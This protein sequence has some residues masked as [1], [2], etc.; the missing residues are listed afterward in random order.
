[1]P[2][3]PHRQTHFLLSSSSSPPPPPL[4]IFT[5]PVEVFDQSP[6]RRESLNLR[7]GLPAGLEGVGALQVAALFLNKRCYFGWPF[8]KE[9]LVSAVADP[10]GVVEATDPGVLRAYGDDRQREAFRRAAGSSCAELRRKRGMLLD[11]VQCSVLLH[12]RPLQGLV[13]H[14]DGALERLYDKAAVP[15]PLQ[16]TLQRH[17]N[18]D[19]R[20][21]GLGLGGAGDA[22]SNLIEWA[23]SFR[24]GT[25]CLFLGRTYYG[26]V[27]TVLGPDPAHAGFLRVAV[28]PQDGAQQ[29]AQTARRVLTNPAPPLSPAHVVARKCGVSARVLGMVTAAVWVRVGEDDRGRPEKRDLGLNVKQSELG[30]GRGGDA[31]GLDRARL[32]QIEKTSLPFSFLSPYSP[33]APRACTCPT[34]RSPCPRGSPGGS[35]RSPC[36]RRWRPTS[37]AAPGS[38][39]RSRRG[40][41]AATCSRCGT[42]SGRTRRGRRR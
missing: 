1:M 13:R 23:A 35:T 10:R 27:A 31:T 18:P 20:T 16:V 21:L 24:E 22:Q 11:E 12:L 39:R 29:A 7:M 32:L 17:P 37:C 41:T 6:A 25:P 4:Q 2:P 30:W 26:A 8:L 38:S 3:V 15:V 14:V 36:R 28:A 34:M 33:Q 42:S 9:A 19:P 5:V 40:P